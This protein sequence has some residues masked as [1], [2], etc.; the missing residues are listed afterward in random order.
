MTGGASQATID[1]LLESLGSG[2]PE[3]YLDFLRACNGVEG[4]VGANGYLTLYPAEE[5]PGLN[6]QYRVRE[7]APG[8]V[9][10]GSD[11]GGSAFAIDTRSGNPSSMQ[12]VEV[13]F[14]PLDVDEIVFRCRSFIELIQH[15]A[16]PE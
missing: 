12:Y 9:L 13:P 16:D 3:E 4:P 1:E 14:V 6:E 2:L 11:G 8:L 10:I 15:V 5:L 7:F